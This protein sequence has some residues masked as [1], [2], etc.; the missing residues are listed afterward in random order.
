MG[1]GMLVAAGAEPT[2][3]GV[4]G[5]CGEARDMMNGGG[6]EFGAARRLVDAEFANADKDGQDVPALVFG[7]SMACMFAL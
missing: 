1:V 7:R 3:L 5:D 4:C 2:L 6:D